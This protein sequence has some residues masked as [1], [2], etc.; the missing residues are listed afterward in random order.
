MYSSSQCLACGQQS[1]SPTACCAELASLVGIL[2]AVE[3]DRQLAHA[4]QQLVMVIRDQVA[5]VPSEQALSQAGWH[6]ATVAHATCAA[7][8]ARFLVMLPMSLL[9]LVMLKT[10]QEHS[11]TA[12]W[13]ALLWEHLHGTQVCGMIGVGCKVL[14]LFRP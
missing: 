11:L 3:T 9:T 6:T 2:A 5:V 4:H 8:A 12:A 10:C 1:L 7:A 14:Q 13:M